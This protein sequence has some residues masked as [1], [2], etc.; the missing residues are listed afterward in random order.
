MLSTPPAFALSQDQT[1]HNLSTIVLLTIE[2]TGSLLFERTNLSCRLIS[3]FSGHRALLGAMDIWFS[4]NG[5]KTRRPTLRHKIPSAFPIAFTSL[6]NDLL[7]SSFLSSFLADFAKHTP[8]S[9][10]DILRFVAFS[11]SFCQRTD[12]EK[13][14]S[15]C[16]T[17]SPCCRS[18]NSRSI[19]YGFPTSQPVFAI[20]PFNNE[21]E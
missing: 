15:N 18:P 9:G 11:S 7:E 10:A 3:V 4:K 16:L 14:P 21:Y 12:C 2:L 5:Q 6:H 13:K 17:N 1:L 20:L 8:H 19:L